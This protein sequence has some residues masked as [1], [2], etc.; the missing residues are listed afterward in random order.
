MDI[1]NDKLNEVLS[2]FF[3]ERLKAPNDFWN[4]IGEEEKFFTIGTSFLMDGELEKGMQFYDKVPSSFEKNYNLNLAF[5]KAKVE[6]PYEE[7][8][9]KDY[10]EKWDEQKK[11]S[12]LKDKKVAYFIPHIQ[13]TGGMKMIL[14]QIKLLK[15]NGYEVNI[16]LPYSEKSNKAEISLFGERFIVNTYTSH[17][18]FES[19]ASEHS[20][21][22][23]PHWDH[24]YHLWKYF[25][26]V[27]FYMQGDYD[28]LSNDEKALNIIRKY[29][30]LPHHTYT[31]SSFLAETIKRNVRR[32][33][34][35][36]P[37]YIDLDLFKETDGKKFE[38]T[39][40]LVIGREE[41]RQK[42][43]SETLQK[44][45]ELK[46]QF[47]MDIIWVTPE[48]INCQNDDVKTINNP[49]Q[50]ELAE[51]Y[52]KS[53][54]FVTAS[55][56]EGF[57]MPPLEAMASGTAVVMADSGG[58][59]EYAVHGAN[60][61]VFETDRFDKLKQYVSLL[62]K[63]DKKK[64]KIIDEGLITAKKFSKSEMDKR[65]LEYFEETIKEDFL[66]KIN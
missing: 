45:I 66:T 50:E 14:S 7:I 41:V 65:F 9:K 4:S 11:S 8:L 64:Q 16:F 29:Y 47:E 21:A 56:I 28:M 2:E 52:R 19:I 20:I 30:W 23:A 44:L 32:K 61:L 27:F 62:V 24:L 60:A 48:S 38:K 26:Q 35:V 58:S 37:C 1:S 40:V 53:H 36:V 12:V 39:T 3:N 31:V 49:S 5:K 18:E 51:L 13:L 43:I 6:N 59:R 46:K 17:D 15:D 42:R 10:K 22:I 55:V 33:P 54:I 63:D 25:K 34:F 57:S